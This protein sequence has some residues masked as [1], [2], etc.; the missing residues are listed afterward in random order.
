VENRLDELRRD[1]VLADDGYVPGV[2]LARVLLAVLVPSPQVLLRWCWF[3]SGFAGVTSAPTLD[4]Q[5]LGP[6]E[7]C[8]AMP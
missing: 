7:H 2:D 4:L 6:R 3:V 5:L 1:L 8:L